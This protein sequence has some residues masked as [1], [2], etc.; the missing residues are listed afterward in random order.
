[1]EFKKVVVAGGGVLG[2]QIAYQAA[3]C[4]KEVTIW[5]RS[6]G[7]IGRTQPKLDQ[8]EKDYKAAIEL[9]NTPDGKSPANWCKGLASMDSFDA[10]ECIKKAEAA[11]KN[12]KLELDL[13]KACKDADII[14]ESM[15]EI[16][17]EKIAFY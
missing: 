2:S 3:Y 11:H 7:S 12:I 1:M 5:L 10:E 8:L 14:I 6:E 15:A 16:T 17:N 9:M 13:A 4:G